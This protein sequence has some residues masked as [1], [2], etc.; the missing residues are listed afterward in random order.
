MW[1]AEFAFLFARKFAEGG[2]IYNTVGCLSRI[3]GYMTQALYA[4]NETYFISDKGALAATRQFACCPPNYEERV[5]HVFASAGAEPAQ[6][7]LTVHALE[8]LWQ[9]VVDLAGHFYTPK[10]PLP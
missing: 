6:L 3:A 2:D 1:G 7:T 4:L 9:E 8:A 5:S 10:Y